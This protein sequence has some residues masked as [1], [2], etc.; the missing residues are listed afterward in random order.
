VYFLQLSRVGND[1]WGAGL[2]TVAAVLF[3]VP[4]YV[5]TL[6][7]LTKNDMLAVQPVGDSSGYKELRAVGVGAAVGHG[8]KTGSDVLLGEVLVAEFLAIDGL[9][10]GSV[11]SGEVAA[12]AHKTGDHSVEGR[13]FVSEAFLTSAQ[14]SKVLD[15]LWHNIVVH[16]KNDS[17]GWL[18]ANGHIKKAGDRHRGYFCKFDLRL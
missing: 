8:Q 18:A 7:H 5:H 1:H 6:G 13:A 10:T 2:A 15:S 11:L 12:L 9:A 17:A 4:H 16:L 3:D 14:S